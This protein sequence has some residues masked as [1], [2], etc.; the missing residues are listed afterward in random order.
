MCPPSAFPSS[1]SPSTVHVLH[2]LSSIPPNRALSYSS[3][4]LPFSCHFC[5]LLFLF[6][7]SS[8]SFCCPSSVSS[9]RIF[10]TS[11]YEQFSS[12][13][14]SPLLSTLSSLRLLEPLL[15]SV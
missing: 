15:L 4:V 1:H 3:F 9:S 6:S 12:V 8:S 13:F 14:F 7:I 10:T 2:A 5:T 11:L